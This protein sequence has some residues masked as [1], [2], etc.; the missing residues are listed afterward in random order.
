MA[1]PDFLIIGAPKA[2]STALHAALAAHPQLFLTSPKE[3]KFFLCDGVPPDPAGQRGPGDAHS[4]REWVWRPDAYHRLFDPAPPGTLRG[5]STPFYLWDRQSHRRIQ[6]AVPEVKLVAVVR[7][8]VERAYSNWAHLWCDGLENEAD[9]LAATTLEPQRVAAGYAPFWRYLEI[10]RYGEQLAHLRSLFPAEQVHVVRYRQLIDRPAQTLDEICG[11]LGVR[12]GLVSGV[13]RSNVSTWVPDTRV[14]RA[15]Q[16]A[17]RA[18]AAVGAHLPPRVW[19]AAEKGVVLP[20]LHRGS[21]RRPPLDP[22]VRRELV[23]RF[24]DDI[25]V[26]SS[27]TGEFYQDWLDDTGRGAF[28]TRAERREPA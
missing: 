14:N 22:E 7:D 25:A 2:G 18:G 8:P 17:V 3:P 26:L 23:G 1:P 4:A 19:R 13:P 16:R 10:G 6:A 15:L 9:F 11:F 28:H 27:L 20:V 24:A 12:Q 5:E 21:D